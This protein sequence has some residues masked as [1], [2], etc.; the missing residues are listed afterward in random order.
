MDRG[1]YTDIRDSRFG[2]TALDIA[3]RRK[4]AEIIYLLKDAEEKEQALVLPRI[5]GAIILTLLTFVFLVFIDM[6]LLQG[7]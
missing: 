5:I 2:F 1:A 3:E 6:K 7:K 4:D